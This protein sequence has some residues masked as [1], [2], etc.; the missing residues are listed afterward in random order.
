M[1]KDDY[2]RSHKVEVHDDVAKLHWPS[3]LAEELASA[4]S[5]LVILLPTRARNKAP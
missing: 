3:N 1:P 4:V 5:M 2:R